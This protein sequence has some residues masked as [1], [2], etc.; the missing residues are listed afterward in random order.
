[1]KIQS[2]MYQVL[3]REMEKLRSLLAEFSLSPAQRARVATAVRV[4]GL[5]FGIGG[6]RAADASGVPGGGF[7]EFE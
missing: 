7:A 4:Q 2:V 1:M 6:G 3:N 5:L